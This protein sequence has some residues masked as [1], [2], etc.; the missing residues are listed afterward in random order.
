MEVI[1]FFLQGRGSAIYVPTTVET[2]C[3][4]LRKILELIAFGSLGGKQRSLF[5]GIL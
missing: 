4:Q 2:S 3:L 1:D 5:T